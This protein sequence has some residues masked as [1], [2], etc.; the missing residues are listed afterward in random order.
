MAIKG[1]KWSWG[2]K[3]EGFGSNGRKK[4]TRSRELSRGNINSKSANR[5]T[6]EK[7]IS[8]CYTYILLY[9]SIH[10]RGWYLGDLVSLHLFALHFTFLSR[11]NR[12]LESFVDA[13]NLHPVRTEH[14]WTPEKMWLNGMINLRNRQRKEKGRSRW[15]LGP[16]DAQRECAENVGW[17]LHRVE[18]IFES[19]MWTDISRWMWMNTSRKCE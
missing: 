17:I 14:N 16:N 9:I 18:W 11:I 6:V 13:W 12:A 3:R 10:G 8:C 15:E 19:W 7:C 4:R 5:K 1:A 2:W